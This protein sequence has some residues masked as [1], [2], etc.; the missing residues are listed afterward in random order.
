MNFFCKAIPNLKK[1]GVLN[2]ICKFLELVSHDIF[3]L[4]NIYFLLF[5][6][7]VNLF[8][9]ENASGLRYRKKTMLFRMFG[10][11]YFHGKCIRFC[12]D[13]KFSSTFL[14]DKE[15]KKY[16]NPQLNKPRINFAAPSDK[17]QKNCAEKK[18][19]RVPRSLKPGVIH[20]LLDP[21]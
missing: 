18:N 4:Y 9:T 6:D 8:A 12:R 21:R 15:S 5:L 19:V 20:S 3:P 2:N 13:W 1:S 14:E 10:L 11:L 17:I 7:T 16:F